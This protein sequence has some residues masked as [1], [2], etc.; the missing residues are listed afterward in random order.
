M[1]SNN[2]AVC[3]LS[4]HQLVFITVCCTGSSKSL[5]TNASRK[6]EEAVKT[7]RLVVTGQ[8]LE[9]LS[10]SQRPR[11]TAFSSGIDKTRKGPLS[12]KFCDISLKDWTGSGTSKPKKQLSAN[13]PKLQ[14]ETGMLDGSV[15]NVKLEYSGEGK[16]ATPAAGGAFTT[17]TA[18]ADLF[19]PV[20]GSTVSLQDNE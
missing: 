6:A 2:N 20:I 18:S 15:E 7:G 1:W 10:K 5:S 9:M 4:L 3:I 16:A 17:N 12:L 19:C 8:L 14:T 11:P 13:V